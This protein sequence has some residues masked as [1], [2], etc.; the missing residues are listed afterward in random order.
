MGHKFLDYLRPINSN[1]MQ[2]YLKKHIFNNVKKTNNCIAN[3]KN[4]VN[5]RLLLELYNGIIIVGNKNL[6]C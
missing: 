6:T 2:L 1:A 5:C 3:K 4:I